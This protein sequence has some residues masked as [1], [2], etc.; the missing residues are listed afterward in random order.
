MKIVV[1]AK[2]VEKAST[3]ALAGSAREVAT[4]KI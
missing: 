1:T 3:H 4:T 2:A